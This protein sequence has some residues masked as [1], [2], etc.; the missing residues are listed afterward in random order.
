V[1]PHLEKRSVMEIAAEMLK[2]ERAALR[3]LARRLPELSPEASIALAALPD[4]FREAAQRQIVEMAAAYFEWSKED[5]AVPQAVEQRFEKE[6]PD[7]DGLRVVGKIDRIDLNGE[8]VELLDFK[9]GKLQGTYRKAVKLGWQ[10]Q[11]ALYPWL[12]EKPGARF[13]YIF[14]GRAEPEEGDSKGSP[15]A[16]GFLR[17]LATLLRQGHFIPTSNQVMEKLGLDRVTPCSYCAY[18]SACRRFEPGAAASHAKLFQDLAPGRC[19]SLLAAAGG[20]DDTVVAK[21]KPGAGASTS[22]LKQRKT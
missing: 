11:A 8:N 10:I 9:S 17:E 21:A 19:A 6:F 15:E 16:T 13:R 20:N 5:P 7:I 12:S 22:R 3:S 2:N 18:V 14:L 4:V 1:R